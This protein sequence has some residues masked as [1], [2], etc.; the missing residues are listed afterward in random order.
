[1]QVSW[2]Q[3]D[4]GLESGSDRDRTLAGSLGGPQAEQGYAPL[5]TLFF[6]NEKS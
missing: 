1:M 4:L 3:E 6:L 5:H 2:M